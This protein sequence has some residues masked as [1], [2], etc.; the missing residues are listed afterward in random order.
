MAYNQPTSL[1]HAIDYSLEV[2]RVYRLEIDHLD[3]DIRV[4][5]LYL[6]YSI[7]SNVDLRPI[8]Y[9]SKV[10]AFLDNI[11][12]SKLKLVVLKRYLLLEFPV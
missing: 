12:T 6:L 3:G 5:L 1:V 8:A 2:N 9:Y 10:T 7:K 11:A 4:T